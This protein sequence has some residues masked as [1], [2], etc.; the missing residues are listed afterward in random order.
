MSIYLLSLPFVFLFVVGIAL[1]LSATD[2]AGER[3]PGHPCGARRAAQLPELGEA[4]GT[5]AERGEGTKGLALS[6]I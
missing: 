4:G 5:V 3:R 1:S 6:V 2:C